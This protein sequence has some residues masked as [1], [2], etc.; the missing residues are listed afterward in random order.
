MTHLPTKTPKTFAHILAYLQS[1]AWLPPAILLL[2]LSSLFLFDGARG[3]FRG[4]GGIHDQISAKNMAI[5]ENLSID[6]H[7]LTF[8]HQTLDADGKPA[9]EPYSRFPIG[10]Y[11]LIKLAILPF[12][13]GLSD[14]IY[15]ARMLM[16]LFFAAAAAI[17][18]LSLLRLTS[19]RWIALTAALLAFSSPYCLYYGDA[20]SSEMMVD[21]FG[22]LLVFHGMVIFEQEGRFR[23][24]LFK[25]CIALLLGWHV[26]GLLLPFIVFGVMRELVRARSDVSIPPPPVLC[27][28]KRMAL[29]LMRNRY[30]TLGVVALLLGISML[31]FN[32]T[33]EYFALN[34]ETRLT[35]LPSFKSMMDRTGFSSNISSI[36]GDVLI[37]LH[38]SGYLERQFHRIGA[39]SIPYAFSPSFVDHD[40]REAQLRSFVILGIAASIASLIGLP[41]VRR[42]RI[43]LVTPAL[44]GFCWVLPMR[45]STAYPHHQ[46]EALYYMGITLT[47]FSLILLC[48]RSLSGERLVTAL[49][50]VSA[51]IFALSALRMS[52]LNNPDQTSELHKAALADFEVIRNMTDGKAI[53]VNAMPKIPK[54]I[55][56]LYQYYFAGRAIIIDRYQNVPSAR[57]PDFVVTGTRIDRLASLTPQNQMIFLYEWDDYHR[58]IDE[59]I[60]S[61]KPLIRAYFDVYL[62]KNALMYVK[63]PC[64]RNDAKPIFFLALFPADES[65]LPSERRQHGFDN[66]DFHFRNGE[67]WRGEQC[68][69]I[70]LLPDYDIARIYTGQYI[71][72]ADGSF[73]HL[74]EGEV[75]LTQ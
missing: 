34:R 35:E 11:A 38:W 29:S 39:M 67:F 74:W 75:R 22:A 43:L 30:L 37:Y 58:R 14:K 52:Q 6:L 55:S 70:V 45:Y 31:T 9:Y 61:G 15:A 48:L 4:T 65:A 73:E 2:A 10:S 25:T 50:V 63:D 51:L 71:Q 28:L 1:R 17:A 56:A 26:Y 16:L 68:I 18:Y 54:M 36:R 60:E 53:L 46:F 64:R 12:G 47:L 59:I 5:A 24:L 3:Y 8:T 21:I 57:Q 13:D 42:H 41:F 66:F 27:Q 23:Q 62:T 69:S 7:F 32:F 33:N 72:Q 19:N 49:S 20:I 40:L 44:S